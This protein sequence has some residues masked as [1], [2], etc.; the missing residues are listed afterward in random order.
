M[1]VQ[2]LKRAGA[3]LAICLATL[4]LL[5]VPNGVSG[6][7]AKAPASLPT[8]AIINGTD[9]YVN[10]IRTFFFCSSTTCKNEKAT[11]AAAAQ[12]AVSGLTSYVKM[13]KTDVVP[14]D[15]QPIVKK[16]E[17]DAAVLLHTYRVAPK[18]T[19]TNAV[20]A[21]MGIIYYETANVGSDS[22]L[23]DCAITKTPVNF[24][25][26]S[27]GVVGVVYSMQ[28]DTQA[29]S[30]QA[31]VSVDISANQS[32][33]LEA[34]SLKGDANGPNIAFNKLLLEFG[35]NQT[36]DSQKSLLIL[37]HEKTSTTRA[38]LSRL[39][40]LLSAEFTQIAKMQNS[41]AKK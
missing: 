4:A 30:Q 12:T 31:S 39:S 38:Q 40:G 24:K 34:T 17:V 28:V 8:K 26:W 10:S 1:S 41:L 36:I 7:A 6:A 14:A 21:N 29:E 11:N 25:Q 15:L 5:A 19:G 23:L 13:M 37:E 22:Y 2:N 3:V 18:E 33:V 16:Y 27:V 35:V 9:T 20:A 32:L